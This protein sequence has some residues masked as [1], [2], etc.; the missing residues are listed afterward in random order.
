[1][2]DKRDWKFFSGLI[3]LSMMLAACGGGGTTP[4]SGDKP[5][6]PG[7][8]STEIMTSSSGFVCPVPSPK[9]EVTS[10]ELNLFVWVDYIPTDMIECYEKV[11]G[12]KVNRDEYSSSEEMYSKI[13]SGSTNYDLVQPTDNI[14]DLIIRQNLL[15]KL[16]HSKL[17][18]IKNF[19]PNYMNLE[20]DPGN[21]YTLP[22]QSGMYAIVY[23]ADKVP[24]PP[25]SWVDLWKAEYAGRMVFLDDPRVIIGLTLLALGFDP[26]TTDPAQLDKAK[27]KLTQLIPSIK[28]FDSNSPKTAL[29]AGDVDLGMTWTGEAFLAQK[30]NSAIK[31]VY[32]AEGGILW[33]DNWAIPSGAVHMDAVYAW[34]NYTLQGD[35][36]WLMLRDFPYTNP[37]SAAL[38]YA[39]NAQPKLYETYMGSNITNA[40]AE[41][42]KNGKRIKDVGD[43]LPLYDQI[44]AE[45]KD[46][47]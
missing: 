18:N 26:N 15:Q 21:E 35:V 10:K 31:F 5:S 25:V 37:V 16:D 1:M 28:L 42:L 33:Q 3:V 4:P 46:G 12:V 39:K 45:V 17:P 6:D 13:S 19:D 2:R 40:P 36:F 8:G 47:Q 30:E 22:Y 38:D 24:I 14:V 41:A 23:N 43:A 11:Y 7:T 34:L 9:I 20:Y 29:I 44:W 32:P 27:E